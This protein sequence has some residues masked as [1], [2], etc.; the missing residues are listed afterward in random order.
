MYLVVD[1]MSNQKSHSWCPFTQKTARYPNDHKSSTSLV[2][3]F[4]LR[5]GAVVRRHQRT[6]VESTEAP[7]TCPMCV[8]APDANRACPLLLS[9]C[10]DI[11]F[12]SR[13]SRHDRM[14][15][16]RASVRSF[17]APRDN[18]TKKSKI[19]WLSSR[20][21]LPSFPPTYFIQRSNQSR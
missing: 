17:E 8:V 13:S 1:N 5:R 11:S 6:K 15:S 10:R 9:L 19:L 3:S 7:E 4:I 2:S 18:F 12:I 20:R 21:S 14:Y 16:R